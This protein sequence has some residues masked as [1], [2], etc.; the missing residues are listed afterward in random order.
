MKNINKILTVLII[1]A[2]GCLGYF[3][4]KAYH[5]KQLEK[6]V[7]GNP[8]S[9]EYLARLKDSENK[10]KDKDESNDF[11]ALFQI[12]FDREALGDHE[13]AI[14]YYQKTLKISPNS[15]LAKWNLANIYKELNRK[16]EAENLYKEA[17]ALEPGNMQY[18]NG[19]GELYRGWPGKELEEPALYLRA[20]EKDKENIGLMG[21]LAGY[22]ESIGDETNVK[23]WEEEINKIQNREIKK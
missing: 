16:A 3:G 18:Y 9:A 6:L 4:V 5:Q 15:T 22:F 8:Q 23:Y 2:L 17:I 7:E 19:L 11:E 21:L 20:L 14:E 13:G 10:L 1:L 12:A